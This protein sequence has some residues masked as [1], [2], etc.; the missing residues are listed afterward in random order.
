VQR[1]EEGLDGCPSNVSSL[2]T[3]R[4]KSASANSISFRNH[5]CSREFLLL[6]CSHCGHRHPVLTGSRD[7]TC[8]A[9]SKER[10]DV[11]YDRYSDVVSRIPN[12][13]F[14]TLTWRPVRHQ[15][16]EIVR[17]MGKALNRFLHMKRYRH[18][19]K[20]LLATVECKKTRSGWFYYHIHAIIS[21]AFVPQSLISADWRKASGFPIVW[22]TRISRT[23]KRALRYVLK[24]VLKGF[25]FEKNKDRL[26]FKTSM[27][28][29]RYIRSYGEFYNSEYLSADHVYFPCPE[30]KSIKCWV[31]LDYCGLVDLFEGKPYDNG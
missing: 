13:K 23:P 18:A 14:L 27:K 24:Y 21:G 22:V 31:L 1:V 28:G 12:L 6:Q 25:S 5:I 29:V 10:Y 30:C 3:V 8:P 15:D 4:F 11:F 16:P 7:R 26:D 20:G 19:W 9:C 2:D 17:S